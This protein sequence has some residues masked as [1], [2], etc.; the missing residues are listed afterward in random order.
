M[1]MQHYGAPYYMA[2]EMIK[3]CYNEKV[4][5]WSIGVIMYMLLTN[6]IPFDGPTD[7]DILQT[8]VDFRVFSFQ[9][10]SW[11]PRSLAAMDLVKKLCYFDF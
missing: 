5:L 8:I 3:G 4:D 6:E 7:S 11:K 9:Q 2:P 10:S 1:M